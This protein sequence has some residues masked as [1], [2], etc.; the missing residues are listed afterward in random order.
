MP[1]LLQN[2]KGHDLTGKQFGRWTVIGLFARATL[3]PNRNKKWLCRCECG[4]EGLVYHG[5]LTSGRSLSCGC[6]RDELN[7]ESKMMKDVARKTIATPIRNWKEVHDAK[8][9]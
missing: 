9:S 4:A 6:L 8:S 5:T 3:K 1:E 2:T 7:G